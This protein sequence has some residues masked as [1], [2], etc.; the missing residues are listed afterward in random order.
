[1][2]DLAISRNTPDRR[3]HKPSIRF[4]DP[5]A[6]QRKPA[7]EEAIRVYVA[8]ERGGLGD[9]DVAVIR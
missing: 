8:S 6:Y 7:V 2:W 3:I 1:M 5:R 4:K 9:A